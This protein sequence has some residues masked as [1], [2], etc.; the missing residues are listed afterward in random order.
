[1]FLKRKKN[2]K[3]NPKS[4]KQKS[5]D[6]SLKNFLAGLGGGGGGEDFYY[7]PDFPL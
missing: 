2:R 1:M 5:P 4:P 7:K 6:F 3:K